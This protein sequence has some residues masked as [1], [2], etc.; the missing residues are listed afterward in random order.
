MCQTLDKL[1]SDEGINYILFI[2]NFSMKFPRRDISLLH[3]SAEVWAHHF[4]L[5]LILSRKVCI[6]CLSTS[7]FLYGN[8]RSNSIE[9]SNT[10]IA[11]VLFY[12]KS[13]ETI[14]SFLLAFRYRRILTNVPC[15]PIQFQAR[16]QEFSSEGVQ[17]S[18]NFCKI[19]DFP[20]NYLNSRI[21]VYFR[22]I[23]YFR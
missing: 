14:W 5:L 17:L 8:W 23:I 16:I 6:K 19:I 1:T 3:E 4:H 20:D 18:P 13:Y 9:A 21:Q 7:W 11:I 2:L 15:K 12:L 22:T 10:F